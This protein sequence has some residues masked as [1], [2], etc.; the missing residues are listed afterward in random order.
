MGIS[1]KQTNK[2][3]MLPWLKGLDT[4]TDEAV[5]QFM[6]LGGGGSRVDYLRQADDIIYG[7]DGSKSKRPGFQYH[8]AEVISGTPMLIAGFDYWAN[9]NAVKSQ[10]IVCWDNNST[11]KCWV[12]PGA[13]GTWS[14]LTKHSTA[15][16]P[17]NLKRVS[18]EVFQDDLIMG[19]TD[20]STL[21][22]TPLKWNRQTGTEYETLGGN[23]PPVKFLRKFQGRLWGAGDPSRPDRLYY[24]SPGNHQEW[25][26]TGDS[27]Y[28]DI[29]PGDGDVSGITAIFPPFRGSLIVAKQNSLYRISGTKP[30]DYAIEQITEGVGCISHN[31]AVA[32]D[33]DDIYFA[34]E[35]GF[36][37]LVVTQKFGDFEGTF[38]SS[39]VQ[40]DWNLLD[41]LHYPYI[42]GIWIP[43]INSVLWNVSVNGDKMDHIWGYDVRYK[44]WYKWFGTEPT[45]VFR[46]EDATT[47]IKKIY[48]GSDDGRLT[49]AQ[50]EGVYRDYTA[51]AI[52]QIVKT[53]FIYPDRDPT[54]QK[55]FK[56]V[57]VWAKM[58]DG[59]TLNIRARIAGRGANVVQEKTI[60]ASSANAPQL[61]VDFELGVSKL[62]ASGAPRMVPYSVPIDGYGHAVQLTFDNDDID[63]NIAIFGFWIEYEPA[64]DSQETIGR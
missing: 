39:S 63:A 62:D 7:L 57:G 23:P 15:T 5:M 1:R 17:T 55:G 51:T 25:Q 8:D 2:F 16:A 21:G 14:E 13:G 18:F 28:L 11:S 49:R 44:A 61:D 9:V 50:N 36:H 59:Q 12:Q 53:P 31:S 32:V 30:T 10:R 45:C 38:L 26:G 35:R 33:L 64:G 29:N 34:S 20:D 27:A 47:K 6:T 46:V 19:I 52:E 54:T 22:R 4:D 40:K 24:S 43:S 58:S 42:Q 56:K 3:V 60:T 48:F 41:K 37:S